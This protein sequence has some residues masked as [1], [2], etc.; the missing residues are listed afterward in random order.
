MISA[1]TKNKSVRKGVRKISDLVFLL[2]TGACRFSIELGP[3]FS[4]QGET[5]IFFLSYPTTNVNCQQKNR[6]FGDNFKN[7]NNI[8]SIFL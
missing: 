2:V 7:K 3:P 4:Q 1:P 6:L 5:H 8:T